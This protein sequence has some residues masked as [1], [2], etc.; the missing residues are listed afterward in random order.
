VG[1]IGLNYVNI[2][3]CYRGINV[4][5]IYGQFHSNPENQVIMYKSTLTIYFPP[6]YGE[7][8]CFGYMLK[9]L[10]R[11]NPLRYK[12]DDAQKSGQYYVEFEN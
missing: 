7:M 2:H 9:T 6:N 8:D 5:P 1:R 3:I 12:W 4:C 10:K 11:L